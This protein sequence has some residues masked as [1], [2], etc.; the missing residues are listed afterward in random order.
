MLN[1]RV[2]EQVQTSLQGIAKRA[3]ESKKYRFCNLSRMINRIS[4]MDAWLDI[5]KGAASGIDKVTAREY[6]ENLV[7]NIIDLEKRL[8][9]KQYK[10][11]LVRTPTSLES[12]CYFKW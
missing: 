1:S 9:E 8:K 5:N 6:E 11:K 4:L 7:E 3:K 10:A 2:R 12:N